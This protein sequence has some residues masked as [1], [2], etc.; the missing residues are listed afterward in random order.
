MSQTGRMVVAFMLPAA[1]L[2]ATVG[3]MWLAMGGPDVG[4]GPHRAVDIAP[5]VTRVAGG[6]ELEPPATV[7]ERISPLEAEIRNTLIPFSHSPLL[8]AAPYQNGGGETRASAL[9][10]LTMAIYYEAAQEPIAGQRAV[11]QVIINRTASPVFPKTI[12]A[13]VQ[14][15]APPA[16]VPIHLHV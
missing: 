8:A 7:F 13:V 12:C 6:D 15:G 9:A 14:Q 5:E 1:A 10:C 4:L 11:A 3:V 2:A 16:R